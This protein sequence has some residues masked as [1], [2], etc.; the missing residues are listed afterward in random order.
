MASNLAVFFSYADYGDARINNGGDWGTVV[1][2]CSTIEFWL[3]AHAVDR[4]RRSFPDDTVIKPDQ[5]SSDCRKLGNCVLT[6]YAIAGNK[7]AE[8]ADCY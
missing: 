8:W 4:S 1:G 6:R 7:V 2:K 3:V 5:F